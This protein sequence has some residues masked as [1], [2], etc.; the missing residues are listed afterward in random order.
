MVVRLHGIVDNGRISTAF[1]RQD[2]RCTIGLRAAMNCS[3]NL[4]DTR[5]AMYYVQRHNYSQRHGLRAA[6][7]LLAAPC[8]LCSA[9]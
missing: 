4:M 8:I 3:M 2:R 6:P 1:G 5:S 9:V 7:Q